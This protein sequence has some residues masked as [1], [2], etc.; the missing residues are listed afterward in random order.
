MISV[1][2]VTV[3]WLIF[4]TK[5]S[6]RR[7]G[8]SVSGQNTHAVPSQMLKANN[9][10]PHKTLS[11]IKYTE[12]KSWATYCT[13]LQR[14][15]Q[16]CDSPC[17]AGLETPVT[18]WTFRY[19]LLLLLPPRADL[20]A[21]FCP[22]PSVSYRTEATVRRGWL[23]EWTEEGGGVWVGECCSDRRRAWLAGWLIIVHHVSNKGQ[24]QREE[25]RT[26]PVFPSS[27]WTQSFASANQPRG[28]ELWFLLQHSNKL[29]RGL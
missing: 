20:P 25:I 11:S 22:V 26:L 2:K 17:V 27:M 9:T 15:P 19:M 18:G 5:S 10:R 3:R 6:R 4:H 1:I 28:T 29:R 7:D 13:Q 24:R 16:A 23:S 21:G 8:K 12:M 14:F